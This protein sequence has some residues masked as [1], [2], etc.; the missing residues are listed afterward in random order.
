[1]HTINPTALI[2]HLIQHNAGRDPQLLAQKYRLMAQSPFVFLRGACH[3]FYTALPDSALLRTA[4][5][6]WCCGDLHFEN[7]GSYKGDNQQVYFDI[8]DYDESALAP[9]T[10]DILRLLTSLHC[11][12]DTLR[13]TPAEAQ[14]VSASC[15]SAYREALLGGKPLWVEKATAK[16]LVYKL[17]DG[18]QRRANNQF[19]DNRTVCDG[20]KRRLI[21]DGSKGL[22][23][24][25]ADKKRVQAFMAQFAAQQANPKFFRVLDIGRR[26]AGTGSL[27]VSRFQVLIRG[28][29]SP[30]H[31]HVLDLKIA[32]PSALL[33]PLTQ[34]GITQPVACN[35]AQRVI[36]VQNRM[37][38]VNHAFL[39]AVSLDAQSYILRALQPTEDRVSIAAWGKKISRLHQVAATMGQI[40]AWDQLR[41]SGR[42]GAANADTLTE[43]ARDTAWVAELQIIARDMAAVT[44]QQWT[45]FT[46]AWRAGEFK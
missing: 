24:S 39:Q 33:Q 41:A 17:L 2:Q 14:R 46:A 8:N 12:A 30:D 21:V 16:G 22:P 44:Q 18:L 23:V 31:N 37:Q 34:L 38:A 11:G 40:L 20:R 45:I 4:P 29:G 1:M 15:L 35:Q 3:L 13:I 19:L 28:E 25:K 27:G 26:I 5:L 10:W 36:D 6:A 42:L 7:F 9:L 32:R 43:F